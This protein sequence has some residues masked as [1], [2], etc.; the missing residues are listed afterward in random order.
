MKDFWQVPTGSMGIGPIS[1]IHQARFMRYLEH[2]QLAESQERHVGEYL[3]MAKMDEPRVS[4]V[5]PGSP[6]KPR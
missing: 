2:R 3:V 4:A 1:A 5:N 6:R